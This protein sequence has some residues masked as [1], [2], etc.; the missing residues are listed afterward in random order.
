MVFLNF[1]NFFAIFLEFFIQGRVETDRNDNFYLLSFS[2]FPNLFYNFLIF[3][4]ILFKFSITVQVRFGPND[5]FYFLSFLA[6]PNTFWLEEK[7]EW[8]INF[9]FLFFWNFL[10]WVG[11]ELIGWIISVFSLSQP[12][13][14]CFGLKR[15]PNGVL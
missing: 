9:F 8:I 12:F 4:T 5:Y 7:P 11:W 1:Q 2:A 13:P 14:T 3:F 15:S 10:L 6:F